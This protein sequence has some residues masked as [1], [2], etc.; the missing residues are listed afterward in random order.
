MK[1][2]RTLSSFLVVS[3]LFLT[4]IL[5]ASP[6]T[7]PRPPQQPATGPGGRDYR[8]AGVTKSVYGEGDTQYWIFEPA[9]PTPESAPLIIFNH[10]WSAMNPKTY[11]A[12]IDHL[13]K[14]GN[15]VVY[16]RYQATLRTSTK[17]FTQNAIQA[18]KDAIH[19]LQ[20]GNHV[21]PQLDKFAI[22]GH[23]AGGQVTAN[24]A[25][26]A[27]SSGLPIPKAI[28]CVQPG[29]TWAKKERAIIPLTDLSKIPGNIL[30][31]TVVGDRDNIAR[32]I[33]AKKIFY[34]TPQIPLSNKDFIILVS[35]EHGK[36]PLV[37]NHFAP[38]AVD[39][40]YDSGE[41]AES[42]KQS[43][44]LRSIFRQRL[45]ERISKRKEKD[46]NELTETNSV[47]AL[48]YY[49][50][51]KLFDGLCDAAFYG[52]N[53]EYALGNTPKQRFMGKWSD[54]TPVKEL[55]VTDNP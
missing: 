54:G 26:L 31:L 13:V 12:W 3:L 49:G 8:H 24:M 4:L 19:Q 39:E 44:F 20:K 36:P 27:K 17:K 40:S 35:D 32:D 2:N 15:I 28:M 45:R 34:Q 50:L 14:R 48:D 51:W 43:G 9:K 55:I 1:K 41:A 18:V 5:Y 33:D 53:R 6:E 16:P 7:F 30:L 21:K 25:A 23:S 52:K 42:K 46:E 11:G 37:A 38:A 47:N 10:G 29:K 22:V